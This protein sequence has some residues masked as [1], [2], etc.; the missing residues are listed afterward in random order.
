M[1]C[2]CSVASQVLKCFGEGKVNTLIATSVL[3]E[4]LDIPECDF[5]MRLDSVCTARSYAQ[6]RGRG[7][8]EL[9]RFVV[10]Y[11]EGT[12]EERGLRR[13]QKQEKVHTQVLQE[14]QR[15]AAAT[16][17]SVPPL[18][19]AD[20]QDAFYDCADGDVVGDVPSWA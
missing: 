2:L 7:R 19:P 1:I 6:S 16:S 11:Q 20:E 15:V 9:A 5:V 8:K 10:L 13:S 14:R 4:G 17:P 12:V 3:E 18:P